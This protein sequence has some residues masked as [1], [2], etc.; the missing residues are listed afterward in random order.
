VAE[1]AVDLAFEKLG[2]KAPPCR[3]LSEP[4]AGGRVPSFAGLVREVAAAG[5]FEPAVAERL[6]HDHGSDYR[7][8]VTL[9]REQ[10]E[11]SVPLPG[12]DVLPADVIQAARHEMAVHL[13]DV[14][15]RRTGLGTGGHPGE[16][17][18]TAAAGLMASELRWTA[19]QTAREL[20]EVRARFGRWGAA[21]P[22]A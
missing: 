18:L 9:A 8:V 10:P 5:P 20:A 3:T 21:P 17:A 22:R 11:W 6:A 12:T 19:D 4:V 15:F 1:Q 14:I 7:E 2:R 13:G 16:P